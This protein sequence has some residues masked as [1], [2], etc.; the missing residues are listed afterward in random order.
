MLWKSL[1]GGGNKTY[2]LEAN[3]FQIIPRY[4]KHIAEFLTYID[5]ARK[6]PPSYFLLLAEQ[7]SQADSD[8]LKEAIFSHNLRNDEKLIFRKIYNDIDLNLEN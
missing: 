7:K 5:K 8:N 4:K 6:Y 2:L 3:A 1:E